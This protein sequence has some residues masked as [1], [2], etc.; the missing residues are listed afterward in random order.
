MGRGDA[1]SADGRSRA[2][3]VLADR[4]LS[5]ISE[6]LERRPGYLVA[7]SDLFLLARRPAGARVLGVTHEP[8]PASATLG[9]ALRGRRVRGRAAQAV[10]PP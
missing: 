10:P 7:Q 9:L 5:L 2:A 4:F 3:A 1:G 8:R 6:A